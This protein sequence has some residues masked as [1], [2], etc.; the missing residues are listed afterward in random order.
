MTDLGVDV[1]LLSVGADL[2]YLTGYEAMPLERLTMLVLPRDGGAT[3]VVPRLEAPR[4]V[5]RSDAFAIRPWAET[6]DP[7]G[8]VAALAGTP[9]VAAIGDRTWARFL[10][11]LSAA[12]P[13]V[14]FSTASSVTGPMRA[15]KDPHEIDMLRQAARAAD[16]VANELLTG[17][18]DLVGRSEAHVAAQ[19]EGHMRAA[20]HARVNFV[21]VAAGENAASPHHEP[22]D[23]VI[24]PGEVVLCD[25]GGSVVDED[26]IGYCSDMTRCIWLG[27][28]PPEA[29]EIYAVVQRANEASTAAVAVDVTCESIDAAARGAITDAGYGEYF[30]HR[31]GHGIGI[32]EHEEPYLVAGNLQRLV[33]GNAFSIEPGV[34]LPGRFGFRL[35]DIVVLT[36]AG[37]DVLTGTDRALAVLE[38]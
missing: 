7:V 6:E 27:T 17:G 1:L 38:P 9:A 21:I 2:P 3:L 29:A 33:A 11:E 18:I 24:E 15:V 36:E 25:L 23:R 12:M 26:G 20:G 22:G 10:V 31:T 37:P 32:E 30:V 13:G 35:E 19:I 5:E 16:V 28:P 8:I 14:S 4:V 34:Y